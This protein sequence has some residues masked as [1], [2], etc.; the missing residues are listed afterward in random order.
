MHIS[1]V[2]CGVVFMLGAFGPMDAL[3]VEKHALDRAPEIDAKCWF[4]VQPLRLHDQPRLILLEFWSARSPESRELVDA[5][6]ELHRIYGDK[7][8]LVAALTGDDCEDARAFINREKIPY[9]VGAKSRSGKKYGI[10]ELPGVVLIDAKDLRIVARWSG[11]EVSGKA[12]AKAIQELLG[13]P[14]GAAPLSGALPESERASYFARIAETDDQVASITSD[15]LAADGEI[16]AE[17]ALSALDRYYE[18]NVPENPNEDNAVT[19]AQTYARG[20]IMGTD[21][22]VGFGKLLSSGRLSSGG[23]AAIRDRVLEIAADDPSIPV[24]IGAIHA[25]RRF[26]GQGGDGVLLEA[27]GGMREKETD[28]MVRAS[29][30]HA[31]EDLGPDGAAKRQEAASRPNAIRL[32]RMLNHETP[33]PSSSP[34]ADAFGYMQTAPQ[35][36]TE[37]LL[38]DYRAFPDAMDDDVGRQNATLKRDAAL[39]EI[40]NRIVRGEIRDLRVVKDH[41]TQAISEEPDPSIRGRVVWDILKSIAERGGSG[42]RSEVVDLFEKRLP[43]EPDRYVRANLEY[44]LQDLKGK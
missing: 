15:I 4:N 13:P 42:L 24:R 43:E 38:E 18:Q 20:A 28:A 33:D 40:G 1:Y 21:K 10:E 23:R 2:G 3:Q 11:R 34:W 37:Q 30:E 26:I 35:R 27:L 14:P 8:L 31:I 9:K 6:T 16:S 22:D 41:L 12:I 5:I 32:R 17:A 29:L 25:L 39:G 7:G 44:A 36:T 19:R